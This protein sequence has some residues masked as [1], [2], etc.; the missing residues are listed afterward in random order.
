MATQSTP[1]PEF[2]ISGTQREHLQFAASTV[3]SWKPVVGWEN[4][5]DISDHGNVRS[6]T[7][8]IAKTMCAVRKVM[9]AGYIQ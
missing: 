3:E 5:A 8:H 7:T 9:R 4:N 1:T 6:V 2:V